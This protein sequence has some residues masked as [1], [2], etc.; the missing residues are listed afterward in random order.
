GAQTGAVALLGMRLTREQGGDER[1]GGGAR[2]LR[3]VDE[4]RGRPLRL[5]PMGVR[6]VGGLRGVLAAA[7]VPTMRG[8]A[9]ALEK[10]FDRGGAEADLDPLVHELVG[11]A[12][13]VVL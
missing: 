13:V 9:P 8:D 12:V 5:R 2:R 4:A 7:P 3:P 11:D 6:H 10:Q 1:G